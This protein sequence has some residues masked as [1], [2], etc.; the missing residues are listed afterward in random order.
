MTS[1]LHLPNYIEDLEELIRKARAK[2]KKKKPSINLLEEQEQPRRSLTP[3]FE[4][5]TNKTLREF[6]DPTT[7]SSRCGRRRIRAQANFDQ[8][9]VSQA[10]L[11]ESA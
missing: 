2:L 5:T 4:A 1:F 3:I 8:H 11:W 9:G 7:A 10:L 6:S